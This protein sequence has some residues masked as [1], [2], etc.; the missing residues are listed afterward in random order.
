MGSATS[1][2]R[3]SVYA[4][5]GPRANR[6]PHLA[7]EQALE[8]AKTSGILGVLAR[9]EGSHLASIFG[10]QDA[11]G[12][13]AEDKLGSLVG[14]QIGDAYGIGG[15]GVVGTGSGAAGTGEATISLTPHLGTIGLRGHCW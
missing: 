7:K 8:R 14:T 1:K 4:I 6:D 5:K 3:R 12:T 10:E 11:L 15:L 9:A 2:N 13:E